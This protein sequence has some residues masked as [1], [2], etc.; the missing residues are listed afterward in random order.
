LDNLRRD[1]TLWRWS[2]WKSAASSLFGRHGL[3]R[4]SIGPWRDYKRA[5]FHPSQHDSS[6]SERWL[7]EHSDRFTPVG[8]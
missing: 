4:Q 6:N 2:T 1:G 3:V 5:D 7:V 8:A